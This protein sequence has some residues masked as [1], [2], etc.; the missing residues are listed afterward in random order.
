MKNKRTRLLLYVLVLCLYLIQIQSSVALAFKPLTVADTNNKS[1]IPAD[2]QENIGSSGM[3]HRKSQSILAEQ[4]ASFQRL[5]GKMAFGR[6]GHHVF[7]LQN[8]KLLVAS[9]AWGSLGGEQ[10]AEILSFENEALESIS[11]P[12]VHLRSSPS[13]IRLPFEKLLY[14]GGS[15]D[16]E[17]A[18]RS[19]EFYDLKTNFFTPGP[20]L[21][22]DRVSHTAT[23]LPGGKVLIVGGQNERGVLGS[24]EIYNPLTNS[25]SLLNARLA[26]ARAN[27]TANLIEGRF[28]VIA[29][30]QDYDKGARNK[31]LF[32][33]SIEVYDIINQRFL[34]TDAKLGRSR[35]YHRTITLSDKGILFLGGLSGIGQTIDTVEIF[36]LKTGRNSGATLVNPALIGNRTFSASH[37]AVLHHEA[38]AKFEIKNIGRLEVSR[39]FHTST[40]IDDKSFIV[41]GGVS[42][43]TPQRS[44]EICRIT[45]ENVS[46]Q[47]PD[48][49]LPRVKCT[50]ASSLNTARWMHEA[51]IN[52]QG[53]LMVVGGLTSEPEEGETIAGP[54]RTIEIVTLP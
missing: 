23:A 25:F 39:V 10:S 29:G 48:D 6:S 20:D 37:Q 2:S 52:Q 27:H 28:V 32:L 51:L 44:T 9:G 54:S 21:N 47:S 5:L 53:S 41:T 40:A 19:T 13:V 24:L 31:P 12:M 38:S 18:Q 8:G 35:A 45:Y 34:K 14:I 43:G 7:E 15:S 3:T 30:G 26:R 22:I 11:L 42:L 1:D 50:L 49:F 16:F 4:L 46:F 33:D 17:M 36:R